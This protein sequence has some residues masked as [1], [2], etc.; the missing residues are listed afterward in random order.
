MIAHRV[1]LIMCKPLRKFIDIKVCAKEGKLSSRHEGRYSYRRYSG[2]YIGTTTMAIWCV[3][4]GRDISEQNGIK[5]NG[6]VRQNFLFLYVQRERKNREKVLRLTECIRVYIGTH[7]YWL[8]PKMDMEIK[9]GGIKRRAKK[10]FPFR[11][12]YG[13]TAIVKNYDFFP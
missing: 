8:Y 4:Q 13:F 11:A 2:W 3:F 7:R 9:S 12:F 6:W 5:W 10:R 1:I